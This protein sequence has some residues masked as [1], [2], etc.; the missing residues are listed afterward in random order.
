MASVTSVKYPNRIQL[1]NCNSLLSWNLDFRII[2]WMKTKAALKKK[3]ANPMSILV[4]KASEYDIE[5]IGVVPKVYL[6][7]NATPKAI[8]NRPPTKKTNSFNHQ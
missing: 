4:H 8:I 7:E 1:M 2:I 5:L 3:V 6:I